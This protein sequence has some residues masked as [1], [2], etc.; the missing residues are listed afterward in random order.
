[1]DTRGTFLYEQLRQLH[2]RSQ[3][4]VAGICICDDWAQ[5]I[6]VCNLCSLRLGRCKS[7]FA[8]LAI[9]EQLGHEEMLH[10]IRDGGHWIVC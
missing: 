4:S 2:H 7:F 6:R 1:M 3:S 10:F 8:L 5:E 9:V